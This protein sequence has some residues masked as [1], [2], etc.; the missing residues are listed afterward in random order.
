MKP[1]RYRIVSIHAL[2]YS[3]C[4]VRLCLPACALA[5]E[6][7]GW[8][9]LVDESFASH[10]PIL[11]FEPGGDPDSRTLTVFASEHRANSL[12]DPEATTLTTRVSKIGR[13]ADAGKQSFAIELLSGDA[14][15]PASVALADL[16]PASR[17]LLHGSTQ[18]RCMLRRGIAYSLGSVMFPAFTPANRYCEVISLRDGAYRYEGLH[19]LTQ[20]LQTVMERMPA[21]NPDKM[22]LANT[23]VLQRGGE[24]SG[25]MDSRDFAV[26][27]PPVPDEPLSRYPLATR[28]DALA[29]ALYSSTPNAYLRYASLMDQESAADLYIINAIL[30][31]T[32]SPVIPFY[33]YGERR[34]PLRFLP[35]WDFDH[36]AD[37]AR[38]RRRPLLFEQ[39]LPEVPA[40]SVLSRRVPVWTVLEQGGDMASLRIHAIYVTMDADAF[41]WFDRLFLSRPFLLGLRERYLSLR[42]T[43]LSPDKTAELVDRIAARLGPALERDWRRWQ[44][45]YVSLDSP[46]ALLPYT[47]DEDQLHIRQ[48]K[49]PDQELV[50]LRY[51]LNGQD[52]FLMEQLDRLQWM[53][54]D[55]FDRTTSGNRQALY[56]FATIIAFLYLTHILTRRL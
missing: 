19:I 46:N 31:N 26:I 37:N 35:A 22:L 34:G 36:A 33:L 43:L 47:D 52:A 55:L 11:L 45:H 30:A 50:K 15:A 8:D 16:P 5:G 28:V 44:H 51:I 7:G 14:S 53:T 38:I 48:T 10:L 32:G 20:D 49:S 21:E 18:D 6:T 39:E 56:S 24:G 9:G 17:W 25:R 54:V 29:R 23:P 3:I 13:Q 40:P 42:K 4:L 2:L 1:G 12:S 41:P 27:Y